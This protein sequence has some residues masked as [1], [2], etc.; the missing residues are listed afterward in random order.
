MS[1]SHALTVCTRMSKS[2]ALLA[3]S[4]LWLRTILTVI[5]EL[6]ESWARSDNTRKLLSNNHVWEWSHIPSPWWTTRRSARAQ[7]QISLFDMQKG[8]H[9]KKGLQYHQKDNRCGCV[10]CSH[11]HEHLKVCKHFCDKQSALD[12]IVANELDSQYVTSKGSSKKRPGTYI[13]YRCINDS[14]LKRKET[15]N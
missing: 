12:W 7:G 15:E 14:R 8:L 1:Q 6:V 9:H 11:H 2:H 13:L 10:N 5:F 4:G 3:T